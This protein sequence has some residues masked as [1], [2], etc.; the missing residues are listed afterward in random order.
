M[1][2]NIV[3]IDK[4]EIVREKFGKILAT[5]IQD[6]QIMGADHVL[7]LKT[8]HPGFTPEVVIL[9]LESSNTR[10]R[11]EEVRLTKKVYPKSHL[12]VVDERVGTDILVCYFKVGANGYLSRDTAEAEMAECFETVAERKR[13]LS[14]DVLLAF[15]LPEK[16]RGNFLPDGKKL[17][18]LTANQ[19]EIARYLTL[20]IASKSIALRLKKSK[21]SI[22][23]T[24]S[25]I[26][27][28]LGIVNIPQLEG[29]LAAHALSLELDAGVSS[30][31]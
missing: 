14:S 1:H 17:D 16:S 4:H 2:T 12:I 5:Q 25:A 10:H 31:R 28:K 22:S 30:D 19:L 20:G 13:Y 26:F 9:G 11:I 18:S 8:T 15:L 24:K 27:R 7:S 21:S 6:S 3:L 29:L 23:A